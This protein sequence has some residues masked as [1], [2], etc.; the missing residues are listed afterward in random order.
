[1][2]NDFDTRWHSGKQNNANFTNEVIITLDQLTTISRLMYS[3]T[4][5]RG[6]AQ[7]FDIY[8]SKTSQGD[9]FEKNYIRS[10][11]N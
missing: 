4:R 7:E 1:M 2:D 10:N 8:I 3:N 6:F 11:E 9:T 5:T